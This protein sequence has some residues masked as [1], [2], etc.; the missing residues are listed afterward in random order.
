M[1]IYI[2]YPALKPSSASGKS[3]IPTEFINFSLNYKFISMGL[4]WYQLIE[5][6]QAHLKDHPDSYLPPKYIHHYLK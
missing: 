5:Q 1:I 4:K 3:R 2:P 6:Y